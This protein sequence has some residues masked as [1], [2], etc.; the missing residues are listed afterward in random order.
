MKVVLFCGGLGMRMREY[1]ESIPK[2][3]VRIGERPILWHLMK[4]YAH[5]G[6]KDF[7]LCLGWKAADIKQYFL[8]YN[9]CLSNNFVLSGNGQK[10][11]LLS[12][13]MDDWNITFVDT[14]TD[15]NIGQRLKTVQPYLQGEETF[16][17]NYA[18]GLTDLHLPDLLSNFDAARPVG[19]FLSVRPRFNSFHSVASSASG[20]VTCIEQIGETDVW[21]NGGFFAFDRKI[22]DYIEEGEELVNEPFERLIADGKLRT[23]KYDGFWGC[24]DTFKERELLEDLH[25]HGPAPWELWKKQDSLGIGDDD[26]VSRAAPRGGGKLA[27]VPGSKDL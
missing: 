11:D 2:P 19:L 5:F 24:M 27:A 21:M 3:L 12:S 9:E 18:D 25:A 15:A 23:L 20:L 8:S 13:D 4:Y 16:L 1:S 14:G 10:V 17:A 7:I 22:F 26:N 6:H